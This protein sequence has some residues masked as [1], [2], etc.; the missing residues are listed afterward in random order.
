MWPGSVDQNIAERDL[1]STNFAGA[2]LVQGVDIGHDLTLVDGVVVWRTTGRESH[3]EHFNKH[4]N[5]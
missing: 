4:V 2:G 3:V 5:V 1:V